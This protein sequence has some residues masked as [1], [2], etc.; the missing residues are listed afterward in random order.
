MMRVFSYFVCD[1]FKNKIHTLLLQIA[2]MIAIFI[3]SSLLL[4]NISGAN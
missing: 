3:S 1:I 2:S 4:G